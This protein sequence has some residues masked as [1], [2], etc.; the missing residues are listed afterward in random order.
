MESVIEESVQDFGQEIQ[1]KGKCMQ[2]S[3]AYKVGNLLWREKRK[4]LAVAILQQGIPTQ[5]PEKSRALYTRFSCVERID[6]RENRHV[7]LQ[8]MQV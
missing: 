1:E 5:L 8:V 3:T 4:I 6:E 2:K 7:W